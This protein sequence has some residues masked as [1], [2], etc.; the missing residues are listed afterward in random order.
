MKPQS[1]YRPRP[2]APSLATNQ[3]CESGQ[4][5][6]YPDRGLGL[7]APNMGPLAGTAH[8]NSVTMD[9]NGALYATQGGWLSLKWPGWG[10]SPGP[11]A[12]LLYPLPPRFPPL[13]LAPNCWMGILRERGQDSQSRG[14][15]KQWKD[16]WKLLDDQD[17]PVHCSD[18]KTEE[19]D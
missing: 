3:L 8:R 12:C 1:S 7:S 17:Q 4:V 6:S 15:G 19:A 16:P 5:P 11:Q 9:V 10:P 13:I 2:R 14:H 18:G